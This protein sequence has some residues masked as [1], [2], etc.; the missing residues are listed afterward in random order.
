[1]Q[2]QKILDQKMTLKRYR[3][4]VLAIAALAGV[5][6]LG[7]TAEAQIYPS[8]YGSAEAG[9]R[10]SQFYIA[11]A[12]FGL[13][14]P[15]WTPYFN[16]N[17]YMLSYPLLGTRQTLSGVSPTA[18]FAYA[19]RNSGV[20]LGAGYTAVHN[21]NPGAPGAEGGGDNGVTGSVGAYR[22]G[23]GKRPLYTQVLANY[24]FGSGYIWARARA[25]IPYG[26]ST[27]HAPRFGIEAVG[28]G[29]GENRNTSSTFEAGPTF[30]YTWTPT[31][32][33]TG[34]AGYKN[35]GAAFLA[36]RESAA[37]LKLEFSLSP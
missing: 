16:V 13:G 25:S 9:T 3:N 31:L 26:R 24:N 29:G 20:S 37:Y 12:Y 27:E 33:T 10:N 18:G 15:G 8:Y 23:T 35:V 2:K 34:S 28:Q 1:V 11:G 5:A 7:Q 17:A 32:R 21:P 36:G 4:E 30:E 22:R 14:S 6:L 19:A